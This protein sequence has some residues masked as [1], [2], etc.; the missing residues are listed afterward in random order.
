M[1]YV[2]QKLNIPDRETTQP[3]QP[4][5]TTQPE[6]PTEETQVYTATK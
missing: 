1:I 5:E 3:T 6:T 4:E 2:D